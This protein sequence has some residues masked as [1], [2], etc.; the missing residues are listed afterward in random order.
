MQNAD[1]FT[2]QPNRNSQS[3]MFF[4][5]SI[6]LIS[7]HFTTLNCGSYFRAL[8]IFLQHFN[9]PCL[10]AEAA[11]L[12]LCNCTAPCSTSKFIIDFL[13]LHKSCT[14][15][16]EQSRIF[17]SNGY[18][19]GERRKNLQILRREC[20]CLCALNIKNTDCDPARVHR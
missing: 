11:L 12:H 9:P 7:L 1:D 19:V 4:L 15:F 8:Q 18:L 5:G 3:G 17:H 13:H 2:S 14:C 16:R 6:G 20:P 10:E